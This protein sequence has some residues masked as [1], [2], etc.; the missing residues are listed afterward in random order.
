MGD[1]GIKAS[2]VFEFPNAQTL[3]D[4]IDGEEFNSLNQNREEAYKKIGLMICQAL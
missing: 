2:A 1:G 4:M 3:K